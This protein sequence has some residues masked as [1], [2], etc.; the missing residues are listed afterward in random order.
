MQLCDICS[1]CGLSL[2]LLIGALLISVPTVGADEDTTQRL[3]RE[4]AELRALMEELKNAGLA[5]ERLAEVEKRLEVLAVEVENLKMGEAAVT[6]TVDGAR[7]GLGPAASK[8][9]GVDRGVSVGGYG[10]A[11]LEV[12]DD[13]REDG[14]PSGK[15]V[16]FDLLRGV[17][18]FGY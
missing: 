14:S 16:Q 2:I 6:A 7:A 3:E 10:E 18:Y 9:Y 5:E 13:T 12:F 1:R 4:V 17:L 8:V 15:T 11:L